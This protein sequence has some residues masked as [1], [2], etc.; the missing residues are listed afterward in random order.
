MIV[1]NPLKI[2]SKF[3]K[4]LKK[5][6]KIL[7]YGSLECPCCHSKEYIKW[8]FYERGVTYFKN[9]VIVSEVI[10]IQRIKC[11]SCEKTHALFPF[12]ITPYKQLTDEVLLSILTNEIETYLFSEDV[13]IYYK[14]Q[15]MKHHYPYLSTMLHLKCS[16]QILKLLQQKMEILKQ[17]IKDHGK[18]FIQIKLGY[19]SYCSF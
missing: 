7:N 16:E 3:Q 2:N 10:R 4:K 15:F 9:G 19:L 1:L 17:Y 5:Y 14:K 13:Y 12:G 6:Q 18:C 8:G 11:Q